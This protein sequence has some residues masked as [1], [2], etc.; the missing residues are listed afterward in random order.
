MRKIPL[1]RNEGEGGDNQE[2]HVQRQQHLFDAGLFLNRVHDEDRARRDAKG[3]QKK[4]LS[5]QKMLMALDKIIMY[6]VS[7]HYSMKYA[8]TALQQEILDA[9]SIEKSSIEA[10][11][12]DWISQLKK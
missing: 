2:G 1:H 3:I 6:K 9:L 10:I 7:E 12:T 4:N 8:Y 5:V 11:V